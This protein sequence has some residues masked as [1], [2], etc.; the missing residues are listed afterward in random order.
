M[1]E[2]DAIFAR[3]CAALPDLRRHWPIRSFALFGSVARDEA[4]AD[5]DLN[6]LV[7]FDRPID[8]F[9]FFALEEARAGVAG[10][11]VDLVSRG[12]LKRHIGHRLLA[13][14]IPL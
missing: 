13:E 5:S 10:R 6:V 8:L 7:E 11:C 1:S 2:K 14:A 12:A 9:A 3:L 4:T